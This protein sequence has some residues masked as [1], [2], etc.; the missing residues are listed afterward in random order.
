MLVKFEKFS[1]L[2][3]PAGNR[4]NR[5][6]WVASVLETHRIVLVGSHSSGLGIEHRFFCWIP[7]SLRIL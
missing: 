7:Y 6:C 3:E 2:V 1:K 5:L 4:F